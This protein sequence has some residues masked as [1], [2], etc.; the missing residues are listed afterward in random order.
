MQHLEVNITKHD[1]YIFELPPGCHI[2]GAHSPCGNFVAD[3][4]RHARSTRAPLKNHGCPTFHREANRLPRSNR[5]RSWVRQTCTSRGWLLNLGRYFSRVVALTAD[6][7]FTDNIAE[8]NMA[9]VV[10]CS[11][12][13]VTEVGATAT[14]ALLAGT[15]PTECTHLRVGVHV[16]SKR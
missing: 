6:V 16:K 11:A 7:M 4:A 13:V 14:Y 15:C 3:T 8:A 2:T 10:V 12:F 5:G 1:T 9:L